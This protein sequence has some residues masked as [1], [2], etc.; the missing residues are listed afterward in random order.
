VKEK[1]KEKFIKKIYFFKLIVS[2][3]KLLLLLPFLPQ[4]YF[5]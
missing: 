3:G 5:H 1:L 4:D 2:A